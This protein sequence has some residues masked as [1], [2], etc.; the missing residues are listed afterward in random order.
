[1]RCEARKEEVET[2]ARPSEAVDLGEGKAK[3]EVKGDWV[4]PFHSNHEVTEE[5]M[6][7]EAATILEIVEVN[8]NGDYDGWGC[9]VVT[10]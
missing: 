2:R 7:Q 1:M 5:G 9:P 8:G 10:E 3:G 4:V 6:A